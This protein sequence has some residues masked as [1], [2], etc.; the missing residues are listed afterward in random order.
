MTDSSAVVTGGVDLDVV[1]AAVRACPGVDDLDGG[2][3]GSVVS[4]LPGRR[5]PGLRVDDDRVTI[6]VRGH[7]GIPIADIGDEV[8]SAVTPLVAGRSIDIIVSDI[9]TPDDADTGLGSTQTDGDGGWTTT[10]DSGDVRSSE[11]ITPTPAGKP[12]GS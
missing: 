4:Y 8:V 12:T 10:S 3:A 2:A 1:S 7:W 6:Q 9:S 11:P 5:M